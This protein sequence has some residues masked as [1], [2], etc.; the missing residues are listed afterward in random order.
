MTSVSPASS[1]TGN[2]AATTR[3]A[4]W[5]PEAEQ[6]V[7]GA[8]LLDSDAG[9]TAIEM[10]RDRDFYR[11]SHRRI[12]R[13]MAKLLERG[14]VIDPVMLRN[15]LERGGDLEASGGTDFIADL[16]DI[17]PTAANV[18]YH[19][20]IVREKSLVRRLID[21]GTGIV[22]NAYEGRD[23]VGA[24]LDQAEQQVFEVSYQRGTQEVVRIKELM[25]HAMERIE[26]RHRGDDS[27]RGVL[28]G[29]TDLDEM[30]N[31]FQGSDLIIVAAR[32][33]MGKTSFCL[34]TAANA[35]LE[36]GTPTAVFS[37]EMSRDQ[38]VERLLAAES[39]VDLH[40]LRSGK[41]RDD[42]YPKMSRAAGL[43]GTAPIWIDDTPALTLLELR[44]K[45]RRMK[46]E[47]DVG[48]FIVD[49]LQLIRGT[50]RQE[51]RQEEISFI[52]RSL[53]A[54]AREL[55]T[56]VIALSQLSRAPEQ[57]GGDRRPML[58]DLR[59][60]GA[61]EQDA[62]LVIFIYRAEMYR[63][64]VDQADGAE[65]GLTELNL[66]KHRNGPTGMVKLVFHKQ[67]TRFDNYSSR[68]PE[69]LDGP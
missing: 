18:E 55:H 42:D 14:D 12:F 26:A 23:D 54:L 56:P 33:S 22:Q 5:S 50:G 44:S 32:P 43:L 11:D 39:F 8:M 2:G 40:R 13:A 29:F 68:T 21:V 67:Y 69:E 63:S 52:S 9:L 17:V 49:Y 64:I 25:W 6:A 38:L 4:P 20:R 10:L 7:L 65:E 57:R 36:G 27:V 35:A 51:S 58:S 45:A 24:M 48:L 28:S 34:N 37:L 66:A 59:D 15:E 16:L 60:S 47:H 46:A 31:G 61:I 30:T 62:D 41:L 3:Q 53:K 1:L 19:C